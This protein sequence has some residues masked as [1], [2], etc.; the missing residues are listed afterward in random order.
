MYLGSVIKIFG[1]IEQDVLLKSGKVCSV[2]IIL[3]GE[4]GEVEVLG[5]NKSCINENM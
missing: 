4:G 1:G 3:V 5:D 2:F